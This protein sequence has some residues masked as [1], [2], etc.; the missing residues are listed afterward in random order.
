M[1]VREEGMWCLWLQCS[2]G[3]NG[4]GIGQTGKGKYLCW[5]ILAR[6]QVSLGQGAFH[7]LVPRASLYIFSNIN[8]LLVG[9]SKNKVQSF[10]C[11]VSTVSSCYPSSGIEFP[12]SVWLWRSYGLFLTIALR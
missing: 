2:W 1:V 11:L 7:L 8:Y 3:M 4:L 12:G 6:T 5:L 10:R 9:P